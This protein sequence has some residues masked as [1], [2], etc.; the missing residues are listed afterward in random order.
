MRW[1]ALLPFAAAAAYAGMNF[2]AQEIQRDFGV[3]YAVLTADVNQDGK[4][5]IVAINPTQVVW[6]ENPSWAKHVILD[7]GTKKD[8]V[9]IAA[10]DIDGDG[11]L[12]FAVGADWQP[13]NTAAGGSLQ[14]IGRTP[15]PSAPWKVT[16]ITEEP[17]LHRMRWGDV[18]GDGKAE[19]IVAP[20]QGRGT[21]GPNWQ[22]GAGARILVFR[23]PKDP[24]RDPWPVEVADQ[25]LH[26]IHN[27]IVTRFDGGRQDEILAASSEG[28]YLVKR[29]PGGTWSK[30]LI[31]EGNPGEIK[32]GQLTARRRV[33]AT[34]EPWHGNAVAVYE[35]PSGK[36]AAGK[37]WPKQV[38]EDKLAGAHAL[39]W[40]DFDGDGADELAAGWREKNFGIAIYKRFAD[41]RWGRSMLLDDGGVAVED[42]AVAD[43]DG[44][45]KPEIIAV[46]RKTQN[47]KIYWNQSALR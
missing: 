39:G 45:G 14:W 13:S 33:L 44:D 2:R 38:V 5:D 15:D 42:L 40:G 20:L 36:A 11:K 43:L 26:I 29:A 32:M 24:A 1:I 17:T 28:L 47:V 3:V 7:G 16:A 10:H 25:S 37:P 22:Q 34:V 6:F 46:G 4:P 31:G 30:R 12:D 27:L 18:D 23:V 21:K 35:E 9:C 8:N 41:G 19:L